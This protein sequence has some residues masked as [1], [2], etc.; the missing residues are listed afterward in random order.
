MQEKEITEELVRC[1]RRD[2]KLVYLYSIW[3]QDEGQ[4]EELG[5]CKRRDT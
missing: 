1:K 4:I 5:R 2:T 3:G